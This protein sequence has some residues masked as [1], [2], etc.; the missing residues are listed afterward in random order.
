M[1]ALAAI[2]FRGRTRRWGSRR[3]RRS[4]RCTAPRSRGRRSQRTSSTVGH[5]AGGTGC[6]ASVP[7][8][9]SFGSVLVWWREVN[10][11][12][13]GGS[14]RAAR[15]RHCA[16]VAAQRAGGGAR[17]RGGA[18]RCAL[19]CAAAAAVAVSLRINEIAPSR[20]STLEF[21]LA[22]WARVPAP[23]SPRRN[24]T[25]ERHRA[26]GAAGG[27]CGSYTRTTAGRTGYRPSLPRQGDALAS[28][29]TK[30]PRRYTRAR[31]DA[32]YRR[33]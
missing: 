20:W 1:P 10:A 23:S 15:R 5:R 25:R 24:L 18:G 4:T 7:N 19:G 16:K 30:T 6:T 28:S 29:E 21:L 14:S 9:R 17:C 3:W 11:F 31:G 8:E 13:P 27:R 26:R 2:I 33:P 12:G 22:I 32:L